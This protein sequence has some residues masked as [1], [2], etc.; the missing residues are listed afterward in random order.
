MTQQ[1]YM[2]L[3]NFLLTHDIIDFQEYNELYQKGLPFTR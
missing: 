1:E 2:K 3:L